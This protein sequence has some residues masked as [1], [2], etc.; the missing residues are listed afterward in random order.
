MAA[1]PGRAQLFRIFPVSPTNN[2]RGQNR[3]ERMEDAGTYLAT[4]DDRFRRV[5]RTWSEANIPVVATLIDRWVFND[6]RIGCLLH[7]LRA[8]DVVPATLAVCAKDAASLSSVPLPLIDRR[9]VTLPFVRLLS[10]RSADDTLHAGWIWPAAAFA[11]LDAIEFHGETR[12]PQKAPG[13][14]SAAMQRFS[15][16]T[17]SAAFVATALTLN[18]HPEVERI[19]VEVRLRL[20]GAKR[21]VIQYRCYMDLR[22]SDDYY[23]LAASSPPSSCPTPSPSPSPSPL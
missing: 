12:L 2:S 1:E 10:W 4:R 8:I 6:A 21:A 17:T 16:S 7:C 11:R 13:V 5:L 18:H 15:G 9:I 3:H 14:S 22:P 19:R 20:G 23:R